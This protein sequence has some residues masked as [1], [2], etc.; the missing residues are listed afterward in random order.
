MQINVTGDN[1][2]I[3]PPLRDYV[4]TKIEKIH[5]YFTHITNVHVILSMDKK[6]IQ[7]AE[8]TIHLAKG[9]INASAEE[10]DMY[11][12]IDLLMDKLDRQ[13]IK[14]KEKLDQKSNGSDQV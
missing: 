3:T 10:K 6:F 4:N 7:K 2:E 8:A 12:A 11:A 14:H 13:V 5:R 9:E 1:I